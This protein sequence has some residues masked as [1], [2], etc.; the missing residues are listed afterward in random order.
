MVDISQRQPIA[1]G[2]VVKF[3]SEIAV[4]GKC[5]CEKMEKELDQR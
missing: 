5:V 3:I 2:D 1:A 4:A